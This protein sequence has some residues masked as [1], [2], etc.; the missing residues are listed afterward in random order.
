MQ[1]PKESTFDARSLHGGLQDSKGR[2]D[3]DGVAQGCARSVHLQHC[4]GPRPHILHRLGSPDDLQ[5]S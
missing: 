4:N 5:G 2:P 1:V 3:L